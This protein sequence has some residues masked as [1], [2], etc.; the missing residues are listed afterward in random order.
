MTRTTPELALTLQTSTPLQREEV[1]P[2]YFRYNVHQ[3][4]SNDR[5]PGPL[6]T[7]AERECSQSVDRRLHDATSVVGKRTLC[8]LW[9]NLSCHTK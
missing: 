3:E 7:T 2:D 5:A 9:R 6:A 8:T 4:H 1:L